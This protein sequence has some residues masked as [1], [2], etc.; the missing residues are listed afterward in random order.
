M[1]FKTWSCLDKK[2]IKEFLLFS[3]QLYLTLQ[4]TIVTIVLPITFM[5]QWDITKVLY[6]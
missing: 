3:K 4:L 5:R 1:N 2:K 6:S